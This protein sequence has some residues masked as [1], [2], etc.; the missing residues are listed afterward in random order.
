LVLNR[1]VSGG[2]YLVSQLFLWPLHSALGTW[3]LLVKSTLSRVACPGLDV[4]STRLSSSLGQDMLLSQP[5]EFEFRNGHHA[6]A[7]FLF[8]MA[9]KP[10]PLLFKLLT[11]FCYYFVYVPASRMFLSVSVFLSSPVSICESLKSGS[12]FLHNLSHRNPPSSHP[13]APPFVS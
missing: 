6:P 8:Q 12:G 11:A 2:S 5:V 1:T 7:R 9:T 10:A 3:V 13:T 4:F